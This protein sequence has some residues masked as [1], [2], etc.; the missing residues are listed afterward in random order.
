[1]EEGTAWERPSPRMSQLIRAGAERLLQS[2]DAAFRELDQAVLSVGSRSLPQRDLVESA[3]RSNRAHLLRWATGNV[4]A[5]GAPVAPER[6]ED[7]RPVVRGLA[8]RGLGDRALHAYR[9]GQNVIWRR[10]MAIAF[11][12]TDDPDELRRLLDITSRSLT[13]YIDTALAVVTAVIAEERDRLTRSIHAERLDLVTAILHEA[14]DIDLAHAGER[15][16]YQ[17]D[18]PHTAAVI[19]HCASRTPKPGNLED[20]AQRLADF[21]PM[22]KRRRHLAVLA[23]PATLWTWFPA[24]CHPDAVT[25]ESVLDGHPDVRL[26]IGATAFGLDGFRYS[27]S[28]AQ[29]VRRLLENPE[30]PHR[31]ADYDRVQAVVLATRHL[32]AAHHLVQRALGPLVRHSDLCATLRAYLAH[33]GNA[34]ATARQLFLHRNTVLGRLAKAERL[35]PR[36]LQQE[37]LN[38]GLALEVFYWFGHNPSLSASAEE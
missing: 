35:L 24:P 6:G 37:V 25:L 27:H 13:D 22:P 38:V 23:G 21:V 14:D 26:A 15:L 11:T 20:I 17:L 4:R 3:R 12:L 8:H 7:V 9:I 34:A 29:D 28:E 32:A 1:M 16:D 33:Q 10:W 18:G 2:S 5:P 31:A 30:A 19:V 36:P